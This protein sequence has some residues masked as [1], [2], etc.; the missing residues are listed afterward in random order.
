MLSL[1]LVLGLCIPGPSAWAARGAR[2]VSSARKAKVRK[3]P[4]PK[5]LSPS[6]DAELEP[7][8]VTFMWRVVARRV[9]LEV[10]RDEQ[11]T[12]TV[13]DQPVKGR[14]AALSL[15]PGTYYWRVTA[16]RGKPSDP[17][18]L[19]VAAEPE[20][21]PQS[22][23]QPMATEGMGLDL[24]G[25]TPPSAPSAAAPSDATAQ[26][27][28]LAGTAQ[29]SAE[30]T[31][32]LNESKAP[33]ESVVA[34]AERPPPSPQRGPR[35]RWSL[36]IGG[37]AAYGASAPHSMAT[38]RYE[39]G[40]AVRLANPFEL[41]LAVGGTSIRAL[42]TRDASWPYYTWIGQVY[43]DLGGRYRLARFENG[44]V[45]GLVAGRLS[46]FTGRQEQRGF[47]VERGP[48]SAGAGIACR[49][50]VG[51]PV[52]LGLRGNVLTGEKLGGEVE[53]GLRVLVF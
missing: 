5:L 1:A 10:A 11:F 12:D 18:R 34:E 7:G 16:P 13:F 33:T 6:E 43:V 4:Q 20:P 26:G 24:T 41:S 37:S 45:Y 42:G 19:T 21:E 47:L 25:A 15:E 29:A 9:R 50:R 2:G 46:F 31:S 35:K 3:G 51:I 52:E 14:R 39:A 8:K 27:L 38:L 44:A 32:G 48:F 28:D 17:R 36:L 30:V 53:L 49:F 40:V 22:E 23:P